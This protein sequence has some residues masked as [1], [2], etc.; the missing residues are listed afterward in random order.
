MAAK[1]KLSK[2]VLDMKFMKRTKDKITQEQDDAEGRA[3]YASEITDRMLR[4]GECPYVCE[5]SFV[6]VE[7]LVEGRFS[8]RGMNPEIERLL[9]LE[10]MAKQELLGKDVK[11]DVA[12]EEMAD[13]YYG[14]AA[15]TMAKSFQRGRPQQ[16]HQHQ[17]QHLHKTQ[18]NSNSNLHHINGRGGGGGGVGGS[19][20]K[21]MQM[22]ET[23]K[24]KTD[25]RQQTQNGGPA[26]RPRFMKPEED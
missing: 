15:K 23:H 6:P 13:A 5:P 20:R 26:K 2:G 3:M 17:N 10:Q 18:Y 11:R 14:N 24:A 19:R 1:S 16:Q 8:F 9:E 21:L 4:H 7:G 25:Y 22:P 12:D